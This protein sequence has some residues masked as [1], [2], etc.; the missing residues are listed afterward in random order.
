MRG[1]GRGVREL[2]MTAWLRASVDSTVGNRSNHSPSR[3]TA[4]AKQP[5]LPQLF[6]NSNAIQ[7]Y[8]RLVYTSISRL[9]DQSDCG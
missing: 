3:C 6:S 5:Q 4:A 2:S 1:E 7:Q 9:V 8:N